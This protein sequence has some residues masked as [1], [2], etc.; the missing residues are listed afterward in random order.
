MF[1]EMVPDECDVTNLRYL[2][3]QSEELMGFR[4]T[5][6]GNVVLCFYPRESPFERGVISQF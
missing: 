4:V 6:K 2:Y 1:G 3:V 5:L